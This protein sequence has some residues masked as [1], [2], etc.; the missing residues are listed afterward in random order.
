MERYF[1][2]RKSAVIISLFCMLLWGSAIPLIK[3]T[4]SVMC[5]SPE[6]VGAKILVAGIRFCMAG[7]LGL[8]YFALLNRGRGR[9]K[10]VNWRYVLILSLM[11][12]SIQY[13]FYY[14][15]LANTMGVKASIIQSSN[16]FFVVIISAMVMR[17][18]RLTPQ[19]LLSLLIGTVGIVI[20]S[21]KP[22]SEMGFHLN[23][24]GA[25]LVATIFNALATVY[26]RKSGKNQDPA[27]VSGLQFFVGSLPLMAVGFALCR[28]MPTFTPQSILMLLYGGFVSATAFTL[29]SMVLKYQSSGEFGIYK[30]FIPIFGS[31]FSIIFLRERFTLSLLAGMLLVL[32]GSLILNKK[33]GKQ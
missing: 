32:L 1:Q 7:L 25:I 21:L 23:G 14:L 26:V 10:P 28:T 18:D 8:F 27:L 30:L 11:Q 4:Y 16:A 20:S 29:W 6:D 5:I 19:R 2:N 15:G 24:E 17:D 3:S 9:T 33:P 12:T 31:I 13:L 22:G